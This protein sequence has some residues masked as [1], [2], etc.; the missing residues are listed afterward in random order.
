VERVI[1][2]IETESEIVAAS[3]WG[4]EGVIAEMNKNL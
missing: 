1:Q 4:R 2:F 3:V